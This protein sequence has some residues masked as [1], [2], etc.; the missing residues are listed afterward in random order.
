LLFHQG[1]PLGMLAFQWGKTA[2]VARSMSVLSYEAVLSI[3]ST[4]GEGKEKGSSQMGKFLIYSFSSLSEMMYPRVS[5]SGSRTE[6][7]SVKRV[8]WSA[9]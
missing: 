6:R 1:E 8:R 2:T 5:G 3:S 4:M 9:E 7:G